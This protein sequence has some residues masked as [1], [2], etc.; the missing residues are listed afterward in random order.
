MAY[1]N[2]AA[3]HSAICLKILT[4]A[5]VRKYKFYEISSADA[6][7][8][9]CSMEQFVLLAIGMIFG[10]LVPAL[11]LLIEPQLAFLLRFYMA[12]SLYLKGVEI[13]I[14]GRSKFSL[15]TLRSN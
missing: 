10:H 9:S 3:V 1:H 5:K 6:A 11:L 2:I 7:M 4:L 8:I 12:L 15:N 13:D 14:F